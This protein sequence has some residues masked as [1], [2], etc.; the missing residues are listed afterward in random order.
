MYNTKLQVNDVVK[1]VRYNGEVVRGLVERVSTGGSA[2]YI[3]NTATGDIVAASPDR[4]QLTQP[5]VT[6]GLPA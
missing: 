3:F 5:Y 6:P 4:V 1:Y 2:V